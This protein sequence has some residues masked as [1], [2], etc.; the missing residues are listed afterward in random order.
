MDHSQAPVLDALRAYHHAGYVPFNAPG[1]EQGRGIDPRVLDVVGA[2][3]FKSDG[4]ALN[5]LDDRLMRQGVLAD[6][7]G[8][9]HTFFSTCGRR[10]GGQHAHRGDRGSARVCAL[11]REATE[12]GHPV[13]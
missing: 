13:A 8:T 5:G 11:V 7:V 10:G 3:V 12:G 9:E 1:H 6:A 4:I 2:D